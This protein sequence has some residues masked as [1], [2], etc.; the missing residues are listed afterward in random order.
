M[1]GSCSPAH[2]GDCTAGMA[3]ECHRNTALTVGAFWHH[4]SMRRRVHTEAKTPVRL[5]EHGH[6]LPAVRAAICTGLQDFSSFWPLLDNK[7]M[8]SNLS[9]ANHAGLYRRN[10]PARCRMLLTHLKFTET[11]KKITPIPIY[12]FLDGRTDT[13]AEQKRRIRSETERREGGNSGIEREREQGSGVRGGLTCCGSSGQW[14][15]DAQRPV[16][17]RPTAIKRVILS[18]FPLRLPPHHPTAAACNHCFNEKSCLTHAYTCVKQQWPDTLH[19]SIIITRHIHTE[20]INW[21]LH[22]PLMCIILPACSKRPL[23]IQTD[24]KIIFRL[25]LYI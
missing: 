1:E 22:N 7:N 3:T 25:I 6:L 18:H 15:T 20:Y 12:S 21:S 10:F 24:A 2:G 13:S 5:V 8:L 23:Y 17:M 9:Q 16:T 19:P 14:L 4:S 11:L